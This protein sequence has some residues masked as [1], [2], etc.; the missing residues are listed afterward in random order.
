MHVSAA[1]QRARGSS[2]VLQIFVRGYFHMTHRTITLSEVGPQTTIG[3][4]K[5]LL[6]EKGGGPSNCLN[7]IYSGKIL[8]DGLTLSHYNVRTDSTIS[9]N[10]RAVGC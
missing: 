2:E 6:A 4:L 10:V 3:D 1:C 5:N 8:E 7:L 9:M